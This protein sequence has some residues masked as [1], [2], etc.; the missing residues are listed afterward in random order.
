MGNTFFLKASGACQTVFPKFPEYIPNPGFLDPFPVWK[1]RPCIEVRVDIGVG[2]PPALEA[3]TIIYSAAISACEKGRMWQHGL[4]VLGMMSKVAV[5]AVIIVFCAAISSCEKGSMW[6]DTF[7]I[8]RKRASSHGKAR[9]PTEKG[10]IQR[11][12]A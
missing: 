12:S 8:L 10:A 2:R 7:H 11:K 6:Q 1:K 5:E 4:D 9:S 3:D